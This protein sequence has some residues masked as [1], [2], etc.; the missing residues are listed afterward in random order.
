MRGSLRRRFWIETFLAS[1]A[2]VVAVMTMFW[3]QWIETL[4]GADPDRGSGLAEW[5]VVVI[6]V[7]IAITFAVAARLEW[8][9]ARV[10]QS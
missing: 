7:M 8:R 9:R 3:H 5:L 1:T 10:A 2:G 6:L 4:V